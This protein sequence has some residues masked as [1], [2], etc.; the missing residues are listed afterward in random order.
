MPLEFTGGQAGGG[1]AHICCL[2]YFAPFDGMIMLISKI[3]KIL[4][5]RFNEE[6]K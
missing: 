5:R 6:H 3:R 4:E 1:G 2:Y